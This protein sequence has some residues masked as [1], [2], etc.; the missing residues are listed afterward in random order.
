MYAQQNPQIARVAEETVLTLKDLEQRL[1]TLKTTIANVCVAIGHPEAARIAV[2]PAFG[3]GYGMQSV[4]GF[5]QGYGAQGMQGF[6]PTQGFGHGVSP[7]TQA[8]NTG[9]QVPGLQGYGTVPQGPPWGSPFQTPWF[10][11]NF[12]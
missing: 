4:Q 6:S 3:Q 9:V 8:W 7:Y 5:G 1:E 2:T 12:R 10:A 11:H